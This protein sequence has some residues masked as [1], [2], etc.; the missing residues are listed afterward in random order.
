[1]YCTRRYVIYCHTFVIGCF[2]QAS[3]YCK[4]LTPWWLPARVFSFRCM[5]SAE[6]LTFAC[7]SSVWLLVCLQAEIDS[8]QVAAIL[9]AKGRIAAA[10]Y[11]RRLGL[12]T[13]CQDI[14]C[15]LL[16]AGRN[17][18]NCFVWAPLELHFDHFCHFSTAHSCVQRQTGH[19]LF[20][21]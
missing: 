6:V 20:Y 2:L 12:L 8:K 13:T 18:H 21:A 11:W 17:S 7:F 14:S 15:T 10:T 4:M 16:W 1:M 5:R 3:L 9:T 19:I